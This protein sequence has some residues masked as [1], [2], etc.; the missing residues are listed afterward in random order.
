MIYNR[1]DFSVALAEGSIFKKIDGD[2]VEGES[3][4]TQT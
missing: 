2:P 3:L 4:C 1:A